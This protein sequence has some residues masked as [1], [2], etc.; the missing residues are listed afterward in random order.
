MKPHSNQEK[1]L[2]VPLNR[3]VLCCLVVGWAAFFSTTV[4]SATNHWSGASCQAG[5]LGSCDWSD[6]QNWLEQSKPKNDGSADLVFATAVSQTPNVD[7]TWNVRSI[8]FDTAAAAF[9]LRGNNVSG[10][11]LTNQH[12]IVNH[13]A[14]PQRL[15]DR[16]STRLNSSHRTISYAVFCLKKKKKKKNKKYS[17]QK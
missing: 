10:S 2:A 8:L 9:V 13:S 11:F 4:F 17:N 6:A 16:K 14:N 7:D 3:K 5:A 1:R 12:G 15:G